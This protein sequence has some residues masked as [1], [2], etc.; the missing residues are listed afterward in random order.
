MT[1]TSVSFGLNMVYHL[2]A[3]MLN[4]L[5]SSFKT[6][7]NFARSAEEKINEVLLT[8]KR[9]NMTEKLLTGI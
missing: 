2:L 4:L 3:Q 5:S 7:S 6:L 9:P 1:I 8:G